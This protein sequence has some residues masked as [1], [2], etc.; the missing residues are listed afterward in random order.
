VANVLASSLTV[1]R[2]LSLPVGRVSGLYP[3]L[4][5]VRGRLEVLDLGQPFRVIVDYAHTPESFEKLFSMVR[6]MTRGRL[7]VVFGSAGERDVEKRPLQ[8]KAASRYADIIVLSDEDP[9]QEDRWKILEDIAAGCEGAMLG[10]NLFLIPDRTEA[11]RKALTAAQPG[12]T[13]LCLGKGH[14]QSIIYADGAVPWDEVEITRGL[15]EEIMG[16]R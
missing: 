8:G 12:D 14:E 9:R 15:V 6:P 11:I 1:C 5:G 7:I 13:V 16:R 2:F 4:K 10:E 3:K